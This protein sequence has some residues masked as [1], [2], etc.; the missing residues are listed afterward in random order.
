M[1]K[2]RQAQRRGCRG[3][4]SAK[5]RQMDA[6]HTP[7]PYPMAAVMPQMMPW[8]RPPRG[9]SEG[10]KERHAK[11][12]APQE[13]GSVTSS[14]LRRFRGLADGGA[15]SAV[16]TAVGGPAGGGVGPRRADA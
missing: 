14:S 1:M 13:P 15:P 3:P 11:M 5:A 16:A 7:S 8:M 6:A 4:R 9:S 10:V 2:V 12:I